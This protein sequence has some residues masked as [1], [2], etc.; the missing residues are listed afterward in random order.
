MTWM[1]F[2]DLAGTWF[3]LGLA[4]FTVYYIVVTTP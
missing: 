2:K 1:R 3:V 4:G